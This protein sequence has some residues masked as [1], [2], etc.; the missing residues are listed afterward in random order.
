[1]KNLHNIL[2]VLSTTDL[3][4]QLL[5]LEKRNLTTEFRRDSEIIEAIQTE[6]RFR[7][8]TLGTGYKNNQ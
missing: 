3:Y 4:S 1:M 7:E 8:L 2:K 6:L 5:F